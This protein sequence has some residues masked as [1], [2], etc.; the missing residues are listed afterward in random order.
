MEHRCNTHI[1]ICK[2]KM[3]KE[4]LACGVE[5]AKLVVERSLRNRNRHLRGQAVFDI[6]ISAAGN[7]A[8]HYS[9]ADILVQSAL[10][11]TCFMILHAINPRWPR[12]NFHMSFDSRP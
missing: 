10:H 3:S 5:R 2:C 9:W 1:S 11:Q 6:D 7:G 8:E 4:N 12:T